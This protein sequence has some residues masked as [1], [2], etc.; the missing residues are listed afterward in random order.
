MA[1]VTQE[2]P[3]SQQSTNKKINF[4]T[5]AAAVRGLGCTTGA[6]QQVSVPETICASAD[7]P[8]QGNKTRKKGRTRETTR[9]VVVVVVVVVLMV[10]LMLLVLIFQDVWCGSGIGFSA[11]VGASVGCVVSKKNASSTSRAN[12]DLDKITHKG[13]SF[14]FRWRST[15]HPETFSF[16][17]TYPDF[18]TTCSFGP[19]TYP[20]HIRDLS[21]EDYSE[22]MALQGNQFEALQNQIAD[23]MTKAL[24]NGKFE[25]LRS[26]LGV[27][28]KNLKE[29]C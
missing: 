21:S 12:I 19:A 15:V 10:L 22:T 25:E 20:R 9:T 24:S 23:I 8:H 1:F 2:T 27:F 3:T 14:S 28:K 11:N 6:S 26:M 7:W 17:Y 18:F 29:E 4:S 5:V 16:P 13:S